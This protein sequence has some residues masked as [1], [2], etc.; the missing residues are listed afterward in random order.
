M[1]EIKNLSWTAPD[2]R[3]II[4]DISLDIPNKKLI[5]ITGP[6]GSGKTTLAKVIAGVE[7]AE[8]GSVLLDGEDISS[9][10]ITERAK[11]GIGFAF[12]QPVRF[13]GISVRDLLMLASGGTATD[14]QLEET[15]YKV[16]LQPEK[17]LHRDVDAH[18]SGGEI[19]RVEIATVLLRNSK[20]MLFDEPEAGIDIWSFNNLIDAFS[21]LKKNT[22]SS[23]IIISHQERILAIA[24]EIVL[25][26]NGRI[27]EHAAKDDIFPR[28]FCMNSENCGKK[29]CGCPKE[30]K[31]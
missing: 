23:I 18:L 16:G 13:K 7:T 30:V 27:K 25:L 2:G 31:A 14:R 4:N 9:L 12:Q 3:K 28:L 8:S 22:D 1:L 29:R 24:D 15:L 11:K 10:N 17:Y 6:N 5:V 21:S 26:K 19:K 20:F